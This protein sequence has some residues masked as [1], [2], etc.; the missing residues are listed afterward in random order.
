MVVVLVNLFGVLDFETSFLI[1]C[2]VGATN[3]GGPSIA[4]SMEAPV[5][6][7]ESQLSVLLVQ[8]VSERTGDK[9]TIAT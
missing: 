9:Q 5:K 8:I 6:S 4:G 7:D 3:D 2:W 1:L